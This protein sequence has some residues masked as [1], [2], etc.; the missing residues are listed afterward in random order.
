MQYFLSS[1]SCT[2]TY[3]NVYRVQHQLLV[4]VLPQKKNQCGIGGGEEWERKT[5]Y[6]VENKKKDKK[7]QDDLVLVLL[8]S[9]PT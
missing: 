7:V 5:L 1:P 2:F 6:Y 9:S 3:I 8:C 4:C